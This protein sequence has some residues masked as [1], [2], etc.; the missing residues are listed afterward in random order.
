MT[1]VQ[2][3]DQLE[4]LVAEN[5]KAVQAEHSQILVEHGQKLDLIVSFWQNRNGR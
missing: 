5:I 2:R 1:P 4:P 3:L